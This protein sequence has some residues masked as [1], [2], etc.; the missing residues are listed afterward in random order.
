MRREH[1]RAM[2]CILLLC[3]LVAVTLSGSWGAAQVGAANL[4]RGQTLY[5]QQCA[6]CHGKN[7]DGLGPEGQYLMTPPASFKSADMRRK[8]DGEL[9]QSISQGVPSSP[10]HAWRDRLSQQEMKDII[11][12]VRML[13][14]FSPIN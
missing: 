9:L 2:K 8:T 5:E 13:S 1:M 11:G 14:P 10:M 7:G 12:Y 6:R 3:S 4:K